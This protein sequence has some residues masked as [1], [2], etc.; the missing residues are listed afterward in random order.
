MFMYHRVHIALEKSETRNL[1]TMK[2]I[3]NQNKSKLTFIQIL[4]FLAPSALFI[5]TFIYAQFLFTQLSADVITK[6]QASLWMG[7]AMAV[8]AV[9]SGI[10]L[11]LAIVVINKLIHQ[12]AG[13]IKN[14]LQTVN[15]EIGSIT[16]KIAGRKDAIGTLANT[17]I[18][19]VQSSNEK[20]HWLESL[21]D[22]IPFP[23][24][25]TDTNM[26]WTFIN[27]ATEQ[28][29]GK[30]R[31]EIMGISCDH[32][33]ANI[34]NTENCGIQALRRNLL[35]TEFN[36]A[37]RDFQVDTS[38]LY[39]TQGNKIGH[40]E[41]VQD[42]SQIV[43]TRV[44]MEKAVEQIDGY[45]AQLADGILNFQIASLPEADENTKM[46]QAIFQKILDN[47]T[48]ARDMLSGTI[49]LVIEDANHVRMAAEQLSSA[50]GQ[51]SEATIQIATTIQQVAQ[52]TAQQSISVN[53]SA[54]LLASMSQTIESVSEGANGQMTEVNKTAQAINLI[55]S[56]NGIAAKVNQ[57]AGKTREMGDKSDQI[58]SIVTTIE[59]IA[60]Q[61]NLL[62]LN[63][64][65]EAARAGDAGKG[66]AVVAEEVSKLAEKS[67]TATKE[68]DALVRSIQGSSG[69]AVVMTTS[70]AE[71]IGRASNDLSSVSTQLAS[72]GRENQKATESLLSH[73]NEIQKAVEN[74]ASISEENSAAVEEVSASTEEMSA[75]V[76]EVSASA[77]S[78]L[79]MAQ[80]LQQAIKQFE[81]D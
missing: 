49:K 61:T 39:D 26:N 47:L 14:N 71:D 27:R 81:V 9:I 79:E 73:S 60:S 29:L 57:A 76:E 52:G 77:G 66:F 54:E 12:L 36:Q 74:I 15:N 80:S 20:T 34:C 16:K 3:K 53:R 62:A 50:S 28:F 43:A 19:Q 65:I 7:I 64:A 5:V 6:N 37:G 45:F 32:W 33:N 35:R 75:Q 10:L 18:D 21:L 38:W 44:Y 51:A 1:L 72:I 31:D 42:I 13:E 4:S 70:A 23:I 11:A 55:T 78:L 56:Q 24:S 67:A 59:E 22:S 2:T 17:I 41:V 8:F 30:K 48:Q 63:A 68:I 69:D 25:V 40:I 46:V 58:S